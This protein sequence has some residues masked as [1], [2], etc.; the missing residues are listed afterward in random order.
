MNSTFSNLQIATPDSANAER[1]MLEL[2]PKIQDI[3]QRFRE[4][5]PTPEKAVAFEIELETC[6]RESCRM[7]VEAEYNAIEPAAIKDCPVRMRLAGEE[8]KRRPKSPNEIG[9]LFGRIRLE[10]YRYEAVEPG[11]RSIFPLEMHLGIEAGLATPALAERIGLQC[12]DHTQQQVLD[13]LERHHGI[14]WSTASLRKLSASLSEGLAMFRQPAQEKKILELLR[15]A[16]K[17]TGP[18]H[19]VLV[20]GRDGIMTPMRHGAYREASTATV[21]VMDR[22]GKRLGTVYLGQMPESGQGTLSHQLTS[23]LTGVLTKWDGCL[24]RYVYV[25]D[26]GHHPQ[27]YYETVLKKMEDPKRPGRLL[28]WQWIV[29]F[30]HACCYLTKLREGLFD[31]SPAGWKWFK[32][33][34]HWLRHR[35]HGII[36]VLRSATQHWNLAKKLNAAREKLFWD[37]YDYLRKYAP[38]MAYSRY[39]RQGKPIGSGVTEAA[40]K[41]VFTQRVKQSGM[42]WKVEGGQVIINLR[43]LK[44]SGVWQ[45][46]MQSYQRSRPL[47]QSNQPRSHI[48]STPQKLKKAA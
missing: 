14:R 19:P 39:R 6:C 30:W 4:R 11:E 25:T 28:E 10:R 15:K 36:D 38:R 46:A 24:L 13:W 23:L 33:M 12:A 34:R 26:A 2:A 27:E 7:L 41:T 3:I 44:L 35:K 43:V 48:C 8:Y 40:C 20:V 16:D 29:D 5:T 47:P 37:G 21:Y 45:D 42:S 18:H 1:M 17:S 31:D 9:T 22:R 32:R